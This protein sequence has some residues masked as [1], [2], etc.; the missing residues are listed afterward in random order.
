VYNTASFS[1]SSCS[2]AS[3]NFCAS[4]KSPRAISAL[5]M[6]SA[7]H[8]FEVVRIFEQDTAKDR[9]GQILV[10]HPNV[11]ARNPQARVEVVRVDVGEALERGQR[12]SVAAFIGCLDCLG[13]RG[14]IPLRRGFNG[15]RIQGQQSGEQK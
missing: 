12:L 2:A 13:K 7:E 1:G 15:M 14:E 10:A 3:R 4:S 5:A 8:A 9:L 6:P 11:E